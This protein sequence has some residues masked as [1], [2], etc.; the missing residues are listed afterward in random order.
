MFEDVLGLV[1]EGLIAIVTSTPFTRETTHS[2]T[3]SRSRTLRVGHVSNSHRLRAM[4]TAKLE[5]SDLLERQV[6]I[7]QRFRRI[8]NG[9]PLL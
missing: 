3:A 1:L 7:V 4:A 2:H 6:G 5:H 9:R 8:L